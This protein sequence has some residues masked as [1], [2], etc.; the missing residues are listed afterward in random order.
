MSGQH[1]LYI[2]CLDMCEYQ[3]MPIL[4]CGCNPSHT[5]LKQKNYNK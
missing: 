5:L 2:A 1:V 4:W 3:Y